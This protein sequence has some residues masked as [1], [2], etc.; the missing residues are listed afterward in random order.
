MR[1][2]EG[3]YKVGKGSEACTECP[4]HTESPFASISKDSCICKEGFEGPN[5]GPCLVRSWKPQPRPPTL[6][7]D[8][9]VAMSV[10][11]PLMLHDFKEE[12]QSLFRTGVANVATVDVSSVY[13]A[14]IEP[15]TT[16]RRSLMAGSIKISV[17]IR[18]DDLA[19]S[20]S[21]SEGITVENLNAEFHQ[22]GLPSVQILESPVVLQPLAVAESEN[23]GDG[24]VLSS[25]ADPPWL[26]I[27][28]SGVVVFILILGTLFF[29]KVRKCCRK[30]RNPCDEPTITS[31]GPT[32]SPLAR[33]G[34]QLL[35]DASLEDCAGKILVRR[36]LEI[37]APTSEENI[38]CES[39]SLTV[40]PPVE[41]DQ[42][43]MDVDSEDISASE[44]VDVDL[45]SL[46]SGTGFPSSH[47]MDSDS[48][49]LPFV[50][51]PAGSGNED[52]GQIM[53]AATSEQVPAG[54]IVNPMTNLKLGKRHPVLR[55]RDV[56]TS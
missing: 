27:A 4:E 37:C 19:T 35:P 44:F 2:E 45:T 24:R 50:Q 54:S 25:S 47:P 36:G 18:C 30:E 21:M 22:L 42:V 49:H 48:V 14:S 31:S 11:M 26:I 46:F 15:I 13:I 55:D 56:L 32:L 52:Q 38:M 53:R 40:G 33:E 10:S 29:L 39:V 3:K 17:E 16:Q 12:Q 41:M 23:D 8:V 28:M 9:I 6:P 7:S 1:C 43:V 20:T 5:G 51:T 34:L